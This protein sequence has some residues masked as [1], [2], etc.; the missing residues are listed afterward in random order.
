[1]PPWRAVTV[2]A[3]VAWLIGTVAIEA[4]WAIGVRRAL[5]CE[6]EL[7]GQTVRSTLRRAALLWQCS[8]A[9]C[10]ALLWLLSWLGSLVGQLGPSY[11]RR[12]FSSRSRWSPRSV[13]H[14]RSLQPSCSRMWPSDCRGTGHSIFVETLAASKRPVRDLRLTFA[15]PVRSAWIVKNWDSTSKYARDRIHPN[16]LPLT[17]RSK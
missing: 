7:R 8:F 6:Q 17:A 12:S 5:S 10:W 2:G 9:P 4:Y 16:V 1:V 14:M 13:P 15:R 11:L 3:V